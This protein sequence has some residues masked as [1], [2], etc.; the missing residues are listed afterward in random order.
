MSLQWNDV[1]S[2]SRGQVDRTPNTFSAQCGPMRIVVLTGHIYYPGKWVAHAFP[3]FESKLLSAVTLEEAQAEAV[4]MASEWLAS[5]LE[6][7][8]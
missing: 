1:S 8:K 7:L 4:R 6:G 2:Y 3:L 5:A